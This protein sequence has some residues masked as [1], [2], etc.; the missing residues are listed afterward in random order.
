MIF[1]TALFLVRG[2][3]LFSA[4][5]VLLQTRVVVGRT[6][7]GDEIASDIKT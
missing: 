5:L 7:D 1:A 2:K 4:L 3:V 6:L